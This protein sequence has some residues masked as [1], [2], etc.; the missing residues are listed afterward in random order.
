MQAVHEPTYVH[1]H[2]PLLGDDA[3]L[4][5]YAHITQWGY[6][7]QMSKDLLCILR[8]QP[9][10]PSSFTYATM[11]DMHKTMDAW[12]RA[13]GRGQV[14]QVDPKNPVDGEQDMVLYYQ[15]SFECVQELLLDP[16]SAKSMVWTHEPLENSVGERVYASSSSWLWCEH[17]CKQHDHGQ[18]VVG[19][20]VSRDKFMLTVKTC[21][22]R[23]VCDHQE[24]SRGYAQLCQS[25]CVGWSDPRVGTV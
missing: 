24:Y 11:H 17:E 4:E 19:V 16:E 7:A 12:E 6:S 22:P 14:H 15:D 23:R 21:G 10:S 5:T 3:L 8:T 25:I 1:Q 9:L 18:T 2:V 13:A 20:I